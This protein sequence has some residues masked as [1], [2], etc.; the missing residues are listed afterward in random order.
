MIHLGTQ[1]FSPFYSD[2]RGLPDGALPSRADSGQAW[3]VLGTPAPT[4]AS[5][6]LKAPVGSTTTS[7]DVASGGLPV[8]MGMILDSPPTTLTAAFVTLFWDLTSPTD[9]SFLQI[10]NDRNWSSADVVAGVVTGGVSGFT[11]SPLAGGDRW[12]V[13]V[14]GGAVAVY[15]NG[16][17]LA[18][19]ATARQRVNGSI[20]LAWLATPG[21]LAP[22][23]GVLSMFS[24]GYGSYP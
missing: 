3:V 23:W 6:A 1:V 10:E 4:V 15:R 24:S 9:F 20:G 14:L 22:N 8:D 19:W 18:S 2:F 17:K 11:G 7:I 13:R 21:P 16:S 5:G 12:W